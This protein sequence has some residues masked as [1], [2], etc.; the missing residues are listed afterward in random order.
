MNTD[1]ADSTRA[2]QGEI[3]I[4]SPEA[5]F[6]SCLERAARGLCKARGIDPEAI[7]PYD[8]GTMAYTMQAAWRNAAKELRDAW[9]IAMFVRTLP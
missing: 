9:L 8:N 6:E 2:V 1:N 7:Q 4:A 5:H 3:L